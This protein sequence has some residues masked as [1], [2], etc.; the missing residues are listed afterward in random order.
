MSVIVSDSR[1]YES[2]YIYISE[3]AIVLVAGRTIRR[4]YRR[5]LRLVRRQHITHSELSTHT[6]LPHPAVGEIGLVRQGDTIRLFVCLEFLFN[7]TLD[8]FTVEI[9]VFQETI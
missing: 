2:A 5:A 7:H 1:R 8:T 4:G 3:Q 9:I 6:T